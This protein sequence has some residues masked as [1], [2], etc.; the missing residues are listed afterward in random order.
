LELTRRAHVLVV[1]AGALGNE[2]VKNLVLSGVGN[3][4]LVDMDRVVASNLNR[5]VF[6]TPEDAETSRPKVDAVAEGATRLD[7]S[8]QFHTENQRIE[9][10]G[11][12]IFT[13]KDVVVG[14]LDN[15]ATRVHV[16]ANAYWMRIPYVDG[17]TMGLMGK[18]H[19]VVPPETSC[20]E[21][22]LNSSHYRIIE[23]RYSC[24][25]ADTT[26]VEPK[27]ASEVTTTAVVAAVESREVMKVVNGR[28]DL[29]MSNLFYYDG[30]RNVSDV[31]EVAI[32]PE[33]PNHTEEPA[34]VDEGAPEAT[35]RGV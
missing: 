17:G 14:C 11:E 2:V 28:R 30:N 5:C 13:G 23:Q 35:G 9:D 24:T 10:L 29:L 8:V 18:V 26:F 27:L 6:F 31:L 12:G 32:N 3:I 19:V 25:G 20:V 7:G 34:A 1:G 21:C 33:C 15:L 4:T 22:T 16:N